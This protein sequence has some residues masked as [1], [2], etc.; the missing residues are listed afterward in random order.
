[1][2]TVPTSQRTFGEGPLSRVTALVHTH[3]VVEALLVLTT[4]PTLVALT[5]L[6]RDASNVPLAALAAVPVGPALAAA[7]GA[8]RRPRDIADLRPFATFWRS[9]RRDAPQVLALWVPALVVLTIIGVN[10]THLDAAGVPRAWAV[11]LAAIGVVT[12]LWAVNV[13][14]IASGFAFRARDV[15]RL[16]WFC[17]VAT[18]GVTLGTTGVLLMAGVLVVVTS[19]AVLVLAGSVVAALLLLVSR[20]LAERIQRDFVA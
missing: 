20:P 9:Y 6:R 1:M 5:L 18:P 17:L 13:I 16:A 2:T 11:A 14:V 10:L 19:E 15:A 4:A 7:L 8:L 12:V 3:L